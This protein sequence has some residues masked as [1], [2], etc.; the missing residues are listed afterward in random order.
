[1]KALVDISL[2]PLHLDYE[3]IV[4]SFLTELKNTKLEFEIN[5][6]S[7]QITGDLTEIM[8]ALGPILESIWLEHGQASLIVKAIQY[9]ESPYLER[10]EKV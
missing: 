7:T 2:Y 4:L 9:P 6:M 8:T 1:M 5:N 10:N 3:N